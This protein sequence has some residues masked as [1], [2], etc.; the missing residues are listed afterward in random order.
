MQSRLSPIWQRT[1]PALADR[2]WRSWPWERSRRFRR[3][4]PRN[5]AHKSRPVGTFRR[6]LGVSHHCPGRRSRRLHQRPRPHRWSFRYPHR[7][8]EAKRHPLPASGPSGTSPARR[9][10]PNRGKPRTARHSRRHRTSGLNNREYRR[11]RSP[12]SPVQTHKRRMRGE[13][14]GTK[15]GARATARGSTFGTWRQCT[16]GAPFES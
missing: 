1:D 3:S 6:V 9:P 10:A 2:R 13:T 7:G 15:P 12:L 8:L 11:L 4:C 16:R 14:P 5:P